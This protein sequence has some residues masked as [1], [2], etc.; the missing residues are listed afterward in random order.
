MRLRRLGL[1]AY[2]NF[3]ATS[4]ELSPEPGVINIV[5][6]PNGAGKSVLRHALAELLFGIHPQTP[7]GFQF[8]YNRM[9]L[10]AEAV[11]PDGEVASFVR[12]KGR[13]NTLTDAAG[14]PHPW[15]P[16]R[17]PRESERKRL[18]RLFVL[19]S[20]QL[21][22]GGKALLQT[23]GDLADALL[24]SAGE[25]GS[26]RALAADLG[27]RRDEA[28]PTRRSA[29]AAFYKACDEWT[30]AGSRLA[31]TMVRPPTVAEH[32][33]ERA[34]AVAAQDAAKTRAAE[35]AAVLDRLNRVL[36]TRRHLDE[37][38]AAAAWLAAHTDAPVLPPG[39][40]ATLAEAVD[41]ADAA[42]RDE[43]AA[44]DQHARLVAQ[45]ETEV[46]DEAVL[47]EAAGIAR[48]HA[49]SL[50][51]EASRRD[52][53]KREAERREAE[54]A[55]ARL[56]RELSSP[57]SPADAASEL[58]SAADIA[59]ARELVG[60][61]PEVASART[62]AAAALQQHR[63]AIAAAEDDLA[64]LPAASATDALR[65]AHDEAAADGDPARLAREAAAAVEAAAAKLRAVLAKVP[66]WSGP[67]EALVA[68]AVPAEAALIRLDRA[69]TAARADAE[70]AERRRAESAAALEAAQ[71]R[72]AAI[73][74][75][76]PL[77][78]EAALAAARARRDRGWA[79][80][81]AR[82][83]GAADPAE[84]EYAP[85]TP[86]PLAFAQAM[87]AADDVADRRAAEMER[88]GKVTEQRAT[89]DRAAALV[90][91]TALRAGE[92]R[93]AADKALTDW[94][95][96]LGPIGLPRAAGLAEV[97]GLLAGREAVA[98]ADAE[99]RAAALAASRLR[100]RQAA[101]T[102]EL[103]AAMATTL[104]T[105]PRLL[106]GARAR[107]GAAD[108]TVAQRQELTKRLAVLRRAA[109]DAAPALAEADDR[110]AGWTSRWN[111]VLQRL[112]RPAGEQPGATS[113]VL[114]RL[115]ALPAEVHAAEVA[116]GRITEMRDQLDGF[117][118]ACA[119]IAGQLGEP[120]GEP[121]DVARRLAARLAAAQAASGARDTLVRQTEAALAARAKAG[122][123]REAAQH[124]LDAAIRAAGG[125]TLEEAQRRVALA[126]ERAAYEDARDAAQ[127]RLR[128]D[129]DGLDAEAL[130]AEAATVAPA[131]IPQA[132][133]EAD[134]E[135]AAA[136][137]ALGL[138]AARIERAEGALRTLAAGQEATRASHDR[139]AAAA[140]LSRVLEDALVQHLAAT[141]LEHALAAVE[142]SSGINH[143]LARIG[144][145]FSR[146][147]NGVY[148]RLSPAEEDKDSTEH[149]RLIA[150]EAGGGE[151]HI[152]RLSEGTRDQL[153]L[154]L[155]LVAVE[156]HVA[157]APP[158]P[159]VADDILQTFDDARARAALEALVELSRHVQVI[160]L[161][162]HPHL[163]QVAQGLPV[164]AP[165]L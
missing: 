60:E 75:S 65:A 13:G 37:L 157:S 92:G 164:C 83:S 138:A 73:T 15:L 55:I 144:T 142:A 139:H 117:A 156:D 64:A 78:D 45:T 36:R 161:T 129:G 29:G 102:T 152:A 3:A 10:H 21:R 103:A 40:P 59:T 126:L 154:S 66:G 155:R 85:G 56:L 76:K 137:D 125:T 53:P 77:P 26:A 80:V 148:D 63:A 74:G 17:L 159:F 105:L 136:Q 100:D 28:A 35:A 106:A 18:E 7:M 97:R 89:V 149:G 22:A 81:Y 93:E 123:A 151:K 145:T 72:L 95:E 47:A 69:L 62:T 160:V 108:R 67:A 79:L 58:Q 5:E 119:R 90:S 113:A 165:R 38:D 140:Q 42:A 12:R 20:A 68:L 86:L 146:L 70:A 11:F 16:D 49:E 71:T 111:D 27:R 162:H 143:R 141:M 8:D 128:E 131:D 32:E 30:A 112:H 9:R 124:R 114:D 107:L 54:G 147:T 88:I 52:I 84:A 50:R 127:L 115:V 132:K 99:H 57:A 135:A 43:V 118:A 51:S 24:S 122:S 4:L 34:E 120:G 23:D 87:A 116:R 25:L 94:A 134:A 14:K 91:E 104:D 96:A 163:L 39:L 98:A 44:R 150:H 48:L 2:G 110:M 133:R 6:A 19:D 101:W 1:E 109:T 41:T 31:E 33:R 121:D 158:L 82:L 61:A 153:Y 46:V 130:R